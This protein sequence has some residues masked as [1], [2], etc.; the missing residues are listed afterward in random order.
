MPNVA[1]TTYAGPQNPYTLPG[2][3]KSRL[4]FRRAWSFYFEIEA[5][6]L[7]VG[8]STHSRFATATLDY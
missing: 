8:L 7:L 4:R 6:R 3:P 1:I 2:L 5:Y